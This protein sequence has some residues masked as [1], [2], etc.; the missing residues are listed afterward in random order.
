MELCFFYGYH[1]SVFYVDF[2]FKAIPSQVSVS[3]S[4][5]AVCLVV[6]SNA[7]YSFSFN[8]RITLQGLPAANTSAG[9]SLV[10][11]LPAPI[12][13]RSP[14][15]TPGQITALPPTHTSSPMV[16]GLANSSPDALTLWSIGCVAV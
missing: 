15:F 8:S 10:T 7:F 5:M 4:H 2:F 1:K 14:M 6:K 9:I 13:L 12:T 3:D 11:T 16:M